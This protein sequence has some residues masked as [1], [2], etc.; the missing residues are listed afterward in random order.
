LLILIKI[1]I[2]NKKEV[3][4]QS[5]LFCGRWWAKNDAFWS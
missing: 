5:N 3:S 2:K 4:K 1:T